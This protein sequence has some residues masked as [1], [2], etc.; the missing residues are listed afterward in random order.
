M[1]LHTEKLTWFEARMN[2]VKTGGDLVKID[3][4]EAQERVAEIAESNS[5]WVGGTKKKWIWGN[6]KVQSMSVIKS[7]FVLVFFDMQFNLSVLSARSFKSWVFSFFWRQV[8]NWS[9]PTLLPVIQTW[10][11][12]TVWSVPVVIMV[13]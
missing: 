3:T 1:S 10:T 9:I 6:G 2:C 8:L 7:D 13:G 11:A 5:V 4:E 12:M